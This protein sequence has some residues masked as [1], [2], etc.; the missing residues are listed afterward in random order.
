MR[1]KQGDDL[2]KKTGRPEHKGGYVV[3][4]IHAGEK[5]IRFENGIRLDLGGAIGPS[6]PEIFRVQ[7]EETVRQHLSLQ[8][9]L[10][11]K[12][13]KVLSLF[14]IDRVSSYTAEDGIVKSLFDKTF[15][16]QAR[17]Y[18][19]WGDLEPEEVRSAYF[20]KAKGTATPIDL[21]LE[22]EDQNKGQREAAKEQFALI[23]REKER[24]LSFDEKV[25]FIFA[26]SAL[27]EGWDNPNVFQICTL[28]QTVS[29]VKK[30]QEI[31]R[32]LRL[33][34][35]QNGERVHGDDVNV[36]TV[37]ANQN[38][39]SYARQL[40]QE[41]VDEGEAEDRPPPP[42]NARQ[43]PAKRNDDIFVKSGDF[44][45]FWKR[46]SQ[47]IRYRIKLDTGEVISSCVGRLSY[48]AHYPEPQLVVER[49]EWVVY[50]YTFGLESV[51]G[52]QCR[53]RLDLEN[54]KGDTLSSSRE[55]SVGDDLA[56]I[57]ADARLRG[58]RLERVYTTPEPMAVFENKVILYR[59]SPEVYQSE[60]GQQVHRREVART[61]SRYAIFNLVDRAA[62]DTGLT[63]HTINEIFRR[64]P[65]D[66]K[67]KVF[68]NPEGF[69]GYFTGMIRNVLADLVASSVEFLVDGELNRDLEQLF[70]REKPFVQKELIEAGMHGLYDLVQVDAENER[71]FVEQLKHDGRVVF[72]FK[73]P[74]IFKIDF[75]RLIGN[76]NP[77]WGV[78]RMGEDGKLRLYLVR[79]TKGSLD[80]D[81]L[82][83]PHEKRKV[84]CAERYFEVAGVDYRHIKGDTRAW[85]EPAPDRSRLAVDG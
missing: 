62:R 14:F 49:G 18:A 19:A 81:A 44:K 43:R 16:R 76:Y 13:I 66:V 12:G 53:I 70:P 11:P 65:R 63:R 8:E 39:D 57:Q 51:A 28:N 61:Q 78:V 31:G 17:E 33:C 47:R 10:R 30:R 79:E 32:G 59:G 3:A 80:L 2:H 25:A 29:E 37:V 52:E 56:R 73:F 15:G 72:Y 45:E 58:F 35:D 26:H 36:L 4:E 22:E 7:L 74:P 1:L 71:A 24:L 60:A 42:S 82:Q 68:R 21:E 77:D 83:F 50:K 6:R 85:W 55:Y 38:Y 64:L 54:T 67:A 48:A 40:Q 23:M 9:R 27:K 5:F 34:V 46:L 75:P 84:L 20:A 69:T 41:Y